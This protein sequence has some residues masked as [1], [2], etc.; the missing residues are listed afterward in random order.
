MAGHNTVR[1]KNKYVI[2]NDGGKKVHLLT[3]FQVHR[4]AFLDCSKNSA[5]CGK[6]TLKYKHSQKS[7][8]PI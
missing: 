2:R 3:E 5:D 1:E 4:Q 8:T 7:E 6:D